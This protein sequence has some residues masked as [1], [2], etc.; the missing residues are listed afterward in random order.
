MSGFCNCNG[1]NRYYSGSNVTRCPKCGSTLS[2]K[3]LGISRVF[4]SVGGV[5]NIDLRRVELPPRKD[6]NV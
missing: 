2:T 6:L 1:P 3:K 4:S 5:L